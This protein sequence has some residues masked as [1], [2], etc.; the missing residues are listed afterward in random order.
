VHRHFLNGS[1][2]VTLFQA[3]YKFISLIKKG[4]YHL[5]DMSI[6]RVSVRFGA[7][8]DP[9]IPISILTSLKATLKIILVIRIN[10][11][12]EATT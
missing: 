9:A 1:C 4:N 3:H 8:G 11:K 2:Y 6:L 10:G 7:Y 12:M 5:T